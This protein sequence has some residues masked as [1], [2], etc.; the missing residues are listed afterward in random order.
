MTIN[1]H[2]EK[3]PQKIHPAWW[4]MAWWTRL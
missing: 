4:N 2:R 3:N 1:H